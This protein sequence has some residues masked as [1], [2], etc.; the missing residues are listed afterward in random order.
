MADTA[1]LPD[2]HGRASSRAAGIRSIGLLRALPG[3]YQLLDG[4]VSSRC[5]LSPVF[6]QEIR[7]GL[8]GAF[9]TA[10]TNRSPISGEA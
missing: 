1:G 4:F 10:T 7:S 5:V 3:Q 8:P 9:F 6:Y 2:G